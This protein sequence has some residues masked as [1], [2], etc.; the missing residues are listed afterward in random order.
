[1]EEHRLV[2]DDA[3]LTELCDELAGEP[4]YGFDTEFHT[5]RTYYPELA[6]IQLAWQDQV[7]LVDPLAVNPAPLGRILGGPGIAIGH[8]ADQDLDVLEAACGCV[9]ATVFDTQV[10]AGFLGMSTPSLARLVESLLGD[11][12]PKAD[13]LSD[14]IRRP[15]SAAQL[16]YAA[17]DVAYLLALRDEL[18]ERLRGLGRLEWALDECAEVFAT[19]RNGRVPEE[20]WWKMGDI[21]RMSARQ[22]GVAQELSAWR[23]RWAAEH[24]RP[25]RSVLSDLALLTIS[26]RPPKSRDELLH[27]RGV[28]Q[29][30]LGQGAGAEILAAVRRGLDL[31]KADIRMPPDGSEAQA[32]PAA[33]SV[34][35]GL[36]R[37]IADNLQ[38]DQSLLATR[39]DIARL[40]CGDATRLDHGWRA[41][42]VG[43]PLR[44][45]IGGEVAA[46][47]DGRGKLVL[48]VRSGTAHAM[49]GGA[50]SAS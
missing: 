21:K 33:V 1:M 35:S 22:Q 28:D 50:T 26:Q 5:E 43:V 48:E 45:L 16:S 4:V 39:S 14:W 10:A 36:V 11:S 9:P 25:R 19:R 38:F 46:A 42:I 17:N 12:L 6:L 49:P 32:P 47:F 8:A 34:C 37:Q 40:L 13:R 30:H 31:K 2:V 20:T 44:Q 3:A 24:N 18:T 15:M 27:L 23:E 29:R 41:E 7:A